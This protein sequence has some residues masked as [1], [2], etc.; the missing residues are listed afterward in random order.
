MMAGLGVTEVALL[1]VL[2]VV[3]VAM[4]AVFMIMIRS[5]LEANL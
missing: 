1:V 2:F 3:V 4:L 5:E